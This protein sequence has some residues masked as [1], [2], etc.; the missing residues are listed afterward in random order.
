VERRS[1]ERNGHSRFQVQQLEEDGGGSR[2]ETS[3]LWP[4]LH[5]ERQGLSLQ[6]TWAGHRQRRIKVL[7]VIIIFIIIIIII[8]IDPEG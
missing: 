4:M 5:W 8:I 7:G 1:G 2:V 3:S 6:V